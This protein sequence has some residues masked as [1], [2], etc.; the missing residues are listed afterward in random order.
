MSVEAWKEGGGTQRE[1]RRRLMNDTYAQTGFTELHSK[2]RE[3]E[4]ASAWHTGGCGPGMSRGG[5]EG[6]E[7]GL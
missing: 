2:T 5:A 3:Q 1:L 6:P 4:A 7:S